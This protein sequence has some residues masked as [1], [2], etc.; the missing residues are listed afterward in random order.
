LG[1]PRPEDR[2]LKLDD[3]VVDFLPD[4][5]ARIAADCGRLWPLLDRWLAERSV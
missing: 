3:Y 2:R 1:V 5:V 4:C